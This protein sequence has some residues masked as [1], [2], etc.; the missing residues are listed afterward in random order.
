[1]NCTD[2]LLRASEAVKTL[3]NYGIKVH[4]KTLRRYAASKTVRAQRDVR[5]GTK[6]ISKA[7]WLFRRSTLLQDFGAMRVPNNGTRY[8][9]IVAQGGAL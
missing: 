6:R 8:D 5:P 3:A 4:E 7:T 9:E 1:M 2:P